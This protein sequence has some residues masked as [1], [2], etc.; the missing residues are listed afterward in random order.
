MTD[1]ELAKG[2][3][4]GKREYQLA[5]YKR[6]ASTM[7]SICLRYTNS[8]NDA[9]DVMQ[10]GFIKVFERIEQWQ[11]TG[12][13][14]GW[15]RTIIVNTAL[16]HFRSNAKWNHT[17]DVDNHQHL[18]AEDLDPLRQMHADELHKMISTMPAGYRTVFNLFA[19]EGYGHKEIAEMLGVTE[20]TS[21]TQYLKA[22]AWLQKA[23]LKDEAITRKEH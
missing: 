13:L 9:E 6:Y 14:G 15:I 10:E 18:P 19:V 7:M 3:L 20:N 11:N 21:K 22:R 23:I 2:C 12:A 5:L 4:E 1:S 17:A 8:R 16:S